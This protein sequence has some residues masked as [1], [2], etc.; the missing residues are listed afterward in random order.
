MTSIVEAI[1]ITTSLLWKYDGN[2]KELQGFI[3]NL[4][5]LDKII[6]DEYK[7]I[8]I[9]VI[10][11]RLTNKAEIAVGRN[12]SSIKEIINK[13]QDRCRIKREPEL[14]LAMLNNT[15]QIGTVEHFENIIEQLTLQLEEAYIAEGITAEIA[16]KMAIR[17]E[18]NALSRGLKDRESRCIMRSKNI[19]NLFPN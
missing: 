2:E 11:G 15:S 4:Q 3:S 14:I 13:L 17:A 12:P 1:E 19:Q 8:V 7:E 16:K 9:L 18:N 5:I 10:L 6:N